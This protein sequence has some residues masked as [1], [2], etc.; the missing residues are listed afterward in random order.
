MNTSTI[1]HC[2]EMARHSAATPPPSICGNAAPFI[3]RAAALFIAAA[4]ALASA[5]A[6]PPRFDFDADGSFAFFQVSDIQDRARLSDRSTAVL[7]AALAAAKPR[8]VV[9]TGDNVDSGSNEREAFAKAMEPFVAILEEFQ[10]PFCVTFGN[11]DTE[12]K[13]ENF[14]TRQEQYDWL[15]TRGG[16]LFVDKGVPTGPGFGL[17]KDASKS[18]TDPAD[19]TFPADRRAPRPRRHARREP[20]LVVRRPPTVAPPHAF[21][22]F[23]R[24]LPSSR[25]VREVRK[26]E[27]PRPPSPPPRPRRECR[28]A[29]RARVRRG[30]G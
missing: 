11:H 30:R 15:K 26:D 10:T 25:K 28:L 4:A 9:L 7:R 22:I 12:K 13:G 8:L 16:K 21:S 2:R 24:P 6:A 1:R 27:T 19:Y 18:S 20:R 23:L 29:C 17:A 14:L 5:S 3:R